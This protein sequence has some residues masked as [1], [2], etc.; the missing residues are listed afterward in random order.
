MPLEPRRGHR[1]P[2]GLQRVPGRAPHEVRF[3]G[4]ARRGRGGPGSRRGRAPRGRRRRPPR[5]RRRP[6][7]RV[8]LDRMVQRRG[9]YPGV[10]R[11]PLPSRRRVRAAG[12]RAPDL[13][14]DAARRDRVPPRGG[15]ARARDQPVV[16]GLAVRVRRD[17]YDGAALV[18]LRRGALPP[19]RR[20][21]RRL[22]DGPRRRGGFARRA[23]PRRLR[24][25]GDGGDVR[26]AG[27]DRR[28]RAGARRRLGG[29]QRLARLF[30]RG[31]RRR[32]LPRRGV[33]ARARELRAPAAVG[34]PRSGVLSAMAATDAELFVASASGLE[35]TLVRVA[36]RRETS[37]SSPRA[38][39]P[40]AG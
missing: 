20:R 35:H 1:V 21:R 30:R 29:G 37:R 4:G 6:R 24:S 12:A 8:G 16:P 15:D 3:A 5:F 18:Q 7:R 38:P 28:P 23:A 25:D 17:G 9:V 36:I 2:R 27:A 31:D 34:P 39:T 14:G 40:S 32:L 11:A 22:R 10:P 19:L 33:P 26:S 13:R